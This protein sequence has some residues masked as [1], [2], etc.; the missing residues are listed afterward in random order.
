MGKSAILSIKILTDASKAKAGMDE[1]AAGVGRVQ[2][3]LRRAAAPA[4]VATAAIVA[5]GKSAMDA[6]SRTQQAMGAVD[7]VFGES[8]GQIKSWA[9]DSATAVGLSTAEY[10]EM[11]AV[12]GAQLKNMGVPMGQ[13]AGKTN[14][15]VKMGADLAATYGGT[16][17]EA[18]QA[19]GSALRGETDPI[20]RYGISIKQADIAAKQA[21]DGTDKLTGAAAKQ[22]KTT[23]LLSMVT[24]QA[25]G[26]V[27]QFARES[28]SAAGSAQVASAQWENAQ[29]ALGEA[30]LP[31]AVAVAGVLAKLAETLTKNAGP[32]K[33]VI[34]VILALAAAI[35]VANAAISIYTTVTTVAAIVSQA[36]WLSAL[37]PILLVIAAVALVVGAIV[38]LWK[39]SE[40]FRNIVLGVWDAIRSAFAAVVGWITRNW[41]TMLVAVTGPLGVAVLL[42]T[43][44]WSTIKAAVSAVIG[45]IKTAWN[46]LWSAIRTVAGVGVSVV[47][48]HINAIRA[49]VS[50]V[51][52]FITGAWSAVW[53]KLKSAA[54]G[55]GAILAAPF[56]LVRDAVET[57]VGAVQRLIDWL[58]RIKVP[59][60]SFPKIPGLNATAV[61]ALA[62]SGLGPAAFARAAVPA[63]APG[64]A[65]VIN[66][67]GAIDPEATAR[68]IRRILAAHDGRGG[69]QGVLRPV[70]TV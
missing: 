3:G 52:S 47:T 68:Q 58:G 32:T 15:L 5:F 46:V 69:R 65:V 6:A 56:N 48:G 14:D 8:A 30:L 50:A 41:Q 54:A 13:V 36:A 9:K 24:T 33:V 37:G 57:V 63:A 11:A 10:Q 20:E 25:G 34:G 17:A 23:A 4:G 27:G 40:T 26:A 43:R 2:S 51:T 55:L 59:K 53:A 1:A 16:T 19:L 70:G 42:V 64:A 21:K 7:S 29:A 66:I 44:H 38:L 18:V 39:K 67:S 31:A 45:F 62:P 28:D 60:L 61:P 22:A 49:V 12:I 35:L